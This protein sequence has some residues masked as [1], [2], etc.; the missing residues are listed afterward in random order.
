[1]T[2]ISPEAVERLASTLDEQFRSMCGVHSREAETLRAQAARIAEL[3]AERDTARAEALREA[4]EVARKISECC[5]SCASTE[6]RILALIAK[7]GC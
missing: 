6:N 3:E 4:A 2:D 1:M 7:E 5:P